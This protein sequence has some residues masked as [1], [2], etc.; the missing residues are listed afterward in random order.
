MQPPIPGMQTYGRL[1]LLIK[2]CGDGSAALHT[3]AKEVVKS[4]S[5]APLGEV[6]V[7][8]CHNID[9][10]DFNVDIKRGIDLGRS[11]NDLQ[12]SFAVRGGSLCPLGVRQSRIDK[13][14]SAN[15]SNNQR[16]S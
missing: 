5:G 12:S 1:T 10:I 9:W 14:T 11:Q 3:F 7:T 6:L 2:S 15:E 16:C 4:F 8:N 13:P